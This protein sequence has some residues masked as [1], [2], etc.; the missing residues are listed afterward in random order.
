MLC[1]YYKKKPV[2][3]G[4]YILSTD[5]HYRLVEF[6]SLSTINSFLNTENGSVFFNTLI[7]NF[8][9]YTLK[10]MRTGWA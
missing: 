5:L 9:V 4:L 2:N 1:S 3:I 8:H 10:E 6:Y 7:N